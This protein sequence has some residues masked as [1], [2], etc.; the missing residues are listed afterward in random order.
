MLV[1]G[2]GPPDSELQSRARQEGNCQFSALAAGLC[3]GSEPYLPHSEP[4]VSFQI[5]LAVLGG[6]AGSPISA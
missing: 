5:L 2:A 4:F 3:K 1:I 6:V